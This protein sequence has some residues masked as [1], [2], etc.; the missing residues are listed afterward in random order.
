M[1]RGAA[2]GER[3]GGRALGTPNGKTRAIVA[4]ALE[5]GVSPVEVMFDNMHFYHGAAMSLTARLAELAGTISGEDIAAANPNIKEFYKI[6]D[7]VGAFRDKAQ[8]CAVD[9]AP[10]VHPRLA[11]VHV[12]HEPEAKTAEA[13]DA[14]TSPKQAAERYAAL[15]KPQ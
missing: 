15:L 10:Y 1:P 9:L 7:Q 5:K 6:V 8:D 12:S 13:V 2:P 3:R 4:A 14:L 11:N